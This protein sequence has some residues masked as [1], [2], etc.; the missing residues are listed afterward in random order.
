MEKI[1]R[2]SSLQSFYQCPYKFKYDVSDYSP[3]VSTDFDKDAM[4][5]IHTF[6]KLNIKK[7][8][9]GTTDSDEEFYFKAH[10]TYNGEVLKGSDIKKT[11]Y[12][13]GTDAD[14]V[15]VPDENGDVYFS[16]KSGDTWSKSVPDGTEYTVVELDKAGNTGT[17]IAQ[18]G[19]LT[20]SDGTVFT[21]NYDGNKDTS[22]RRIGT[23]IHWLY[24]RILY[25]NG[26]VRFQAG[27]NNGEYR[28]LRIFRLFENSPSVKLMI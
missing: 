26:N 12:Y 11:N 15:A 4:T 1:I 5:N 25:C 17:A 6:D 7:L 3:N 2:V 21:V 10:F 8:V 27:F 19:T 9:P 16:L 13:L 28:D 23:G 22:I 14:N 20:T 24:H 18:D